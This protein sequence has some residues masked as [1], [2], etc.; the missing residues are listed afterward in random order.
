V[1]DDHGGWYVMRG[2]AVVGA[3]FTLADVQKLAGP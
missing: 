2:D 1:T 3:D